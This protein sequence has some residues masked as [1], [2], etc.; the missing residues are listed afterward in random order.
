MKT[1]VT[2]L[3]ANK[4]FRLRECDNFL[5]AEYSQAPNH[6]TS[7]FYI[8]CS[9]DSFSANE[10]IEQQAAWFDSAKKTVGN[11]SFDKN[12]TLIVL[13]PAADYQTIK[14]ARIQTLKVEE[15]PYH[16]KK[17]VLLYTPKEIANFQHNV[18]ELSQLESIISNEQNFA[19]YRKSYTEETYLRL[20]YRMAQKLPFI[21]MQIQSESG[22]ESL[23]KTICDRIQKEMLSSFNNQVTDILLAL[24]S[25]AQK[26]ITAAAIFDLLK[27]KKG[28]GGENEDS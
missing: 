20:I 17:Q 15:D 16:F 19:E 24:E 11:K 4:G 12:V 8:I 18:Q 22:L 28:I 3:L 5:I 9:R 21:E 14:R 25:K 26:E 13:A 6:F 1:I 7:V 10:I 2:N 27:E 23:E